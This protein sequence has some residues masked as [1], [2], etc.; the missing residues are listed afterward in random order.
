L[1]RGG[2]YGIIQNNGAS[3]MSPHGSANAGL[4]KKKILVKTIDQMTL[5]NDTTIL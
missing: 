4:K 3:P 2:C 5:K 1:Q